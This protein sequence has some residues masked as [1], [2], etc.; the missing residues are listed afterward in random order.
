MRPQIYTTPD[1][2]CLLLAAG[3]GAY[4]I[5]RFL[6]AYGLYAEKTWAE[7]LAAVS[8]AI[9]VPFEI[10]KLLRRPTWHSA[11]FLAI[12]LLIVALMV[13]ALFQ[14]RKRTTQNVA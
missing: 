7:A 1:C 12:N 5:L 9:Y 13:G 4:A 14:H 10:A 11:L 8:G 2:C 3:A 6:E